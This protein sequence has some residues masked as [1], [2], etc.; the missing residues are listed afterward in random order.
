MIQNSS[1]VTIRE[2]DFG[3]TAWWSG[4]ETRYSDVKVYNSNAFK[5]RID[6]F[7]AIGNGDL[8]L[9]GCNALYNYDDGVSHHYQT[10]GIIDG[11][12]FIGN[13]KGGIC[14]SYGCRVNISN[15]FCKDNEYGIYLI[16][17]PNESPIVTNDKL[18]VSNS[19]AIGN[20]TYDVKV[21]GYNAIIMNCAYHTSSFDTQKEIDTYNCNVL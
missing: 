12:K 16:Q 4:L 15:V 2:C 6:G 3:F 21:D 1:L 9:Y 5:V 18:K 19:V 14:P 7:G 17:N 11:G 20:N 8:S 10:T 13:A